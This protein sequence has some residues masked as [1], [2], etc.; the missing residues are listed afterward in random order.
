LEKGEYMVRHLEVR[1][2][3]PFQAK[4]VTGVKGFDCEEMNRVWCMSELI[5]V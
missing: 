1:E 5:A 4:R 2:G 3:N